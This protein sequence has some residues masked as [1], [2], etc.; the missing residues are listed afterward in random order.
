M[1]AIAATFAAGLV[2]LAPMAVAE[3]SAWDDISDALWGDQP[4]LASGIV[5]L[6]A[7]ERAEDA[8]IVPVTIA[9]ALPEGD[10]RRVERLTLVV[11]ENPAPVAATFTLGAGAGVDEI[12]TRLRVD[13]YSSVHVVAELSDGSL[14]VAERFVKASGGCSAPALKDPEAAMAS[15]GRM[16]LRHFDGEEDGRGEAQL[17]IRHPN[18]SGLQRDP[19]THYYIP[20]HFVQELTVRQGD[21]LILAMEGGI[22]ISEDPSFRFAY[23]PNG[24]PIHVEAIDTEGEAFA[25]TW[26]A[27]ARRPSRSRRTRRPVCGPPTRP[28]APERRGAGLV[29]D[30]TPRMAA[31][32]GAGRSEAAKLRLDLRAAQAI[33]GGLGA[34]G[35]AEEDAALA[36]DLAEREIGLRLLVGLVGHAARRSRR[37]SRRSGPAPRG[38]SPLASTQPIT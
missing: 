14:H 18:N 35:G 11:D 26:P 27:Y 4:M 12:A 17:L 8:A 9:T 19:L 37:S 6:Q 15:L 5:A 21:A 28:T 34:L 36:H 22:S 1:R 23:R 16:K 33:H 13:T 38:P 2:A 29:R 31:P 25:K 24:E 7:P 10:A 30:P 3:P 32:A 20:A